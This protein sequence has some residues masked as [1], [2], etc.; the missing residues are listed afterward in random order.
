VSAETAAA[1]A[2]PR[3][4][5]SSARSRSLPVRKDSK[6]RKKSWTSQASSGTNNGRRQPGLAGLHKQRLPKQQ[7]FQESQMD[8][9]PKGARPVFPGQSA[10][11]FVRKGLVVA[12]SGDKPKALIGST[13]Q[14]TQRP[15]PAAPVVSCATQ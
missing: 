1:G 8:A 2:V 15:G 7:T 13:P 14:L 3:P 6:A 5:P 4:R 10:Q 9:R 11:H 12:E